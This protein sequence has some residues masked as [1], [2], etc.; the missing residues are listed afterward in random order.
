MPFKSALAAAGCDPSIMGIGPVPATE[1][2]LKATGKTLQDI[3]LV[4]V[5]CPYDVCVLYLNT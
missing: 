3:D 1:G 5:S 2:L 4:E